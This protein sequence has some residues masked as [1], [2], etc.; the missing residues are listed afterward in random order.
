MEAAATTKTNITNVIM[1]LYPHNN[2]YVL[3]CQF[4]FY[5]MG[6]FFFLKGT[7]IFKTPT[8]FL[9]I[10]HCKLYEAQMCGTFKNKFHIQQQIPPTIQLT[11]LKKNMYGNFNISICLL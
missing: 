1:F 8:H 11:Y 3:L 9:S 5:D 6:Q 10:T 7:H 4:K 2:H